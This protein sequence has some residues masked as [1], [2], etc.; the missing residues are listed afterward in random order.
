VSQILVSNLNDVGITLKVNAVEF[1]TWLNDVYINKNYDL[2]FV[3]H[4]EAHDFENWA[5]PDY[6]FTYDNPEV[7]DLYA[8]SVAATDP[9]Q[10]ADFLKQA[11]K[12]V[13]DDQAADWLYNG[14]PSSPSRRR[15]RV[16]DG[17]RQRAHEPRRPRQEPVTRPGV[18]RY[19]LT[20]LA[21]LL[22]GLFVASA[23]IFLTLRV[24]PGDVAQLIAG[25]NSTPSRSPR[26]ASAS[27]STHP[28]SQYLTWI[29][30]S[31][32]ATS[33]VAAHG[34]PV[35]SELVKRRRSRSRSASWR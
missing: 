31:S 5:N 13:A 21:L 18:I 34:A 11:A 10:A 8:K 30:G 3:L 1:P 4:T 32:A 2:S 20:R 28:A 33:V 15:D 9:D 23:L 29:G 14:H 25:M 19:A 22:L 17:Q 7:Q 35:A 6:Y 27:V 24:L 12:I 26:S 16:P